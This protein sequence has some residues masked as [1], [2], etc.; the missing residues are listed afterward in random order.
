MIRKRYIDT[1]HGQIHIR[2]SGR[3]VV[4]LICLHAT[5]Y[6]SRSFIALMAA[7]GEARHV[8]AIDAPGY[9]DS[10]PPTQ[11]PD[12]A[13]YADTIAAAIA[14]TVGAETPFDL[15]GYHTGVA[16]AAEL[17]I[18]TPHMV[19]RMVWL[20]VPY[21]HALDFEAWR[22]R[23]ARGHTLGAD[24]GQ[25]DERWD[26]LVTGRPAGISLERGFTNFVDELK[27]WPNGSWAHQALFDW[28]I[29]ARLP[30]VTQTTL[31]LNPESHLAEPSRVAARLMPNAT[32]IELPHLSGAVL[33]TAATEIAALTAAF[34]D[35]LQT[36]QQKSAA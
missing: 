19:R 8:I 30:L 22:A 16:I 15:F 25:F 20:G 11:R 24:L 4:P 1:R 36:A 18:V 27:A 3:G 6:S 31:I 9:G 13:G 21:F 23:L 28:N 35:Q 12:M 26:Y 14:G 29:E 33:E 7:F 2:E 32:V 5:A 17:A 34:L 10:D